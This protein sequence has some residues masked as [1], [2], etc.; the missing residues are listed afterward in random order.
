MRGAGPADEAAVQLLL[1][2]FRERLAGGCTALS[3]DNM[4][5]Y[6]E[7]AILQQY[8]YYVVA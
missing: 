2:A 8:Y 6:F 5:E 7:K 4:I 1:A 3:T